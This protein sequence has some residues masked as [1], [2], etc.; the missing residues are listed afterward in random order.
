MARASL[1]GGV[2][3][4]SNTVATLAPQVLALLF[5]APPQYAVFSL[6]FITLGLAQSAQNSLVVDPWL[7]LDRHSSRLPTGAVVWAA[8]P[9]AL[10]AAA[11]PAALG[12]LSASEFW[13]AALGVCAAQSRNSL[14]LLG[15]VM[16]WRTVVASDI[17]F[18]SA[19]GAVVALLAQDGI[20]WSTIWWGIVAG[21]LAGLAPWASHVSDA[22]CPPLRWFASRR[23]EILPLWLES[24]VL[25]LGVAGPPVAFSALMPASDF[26]IFRATSSALL[27]VRLVLTPLR[28]RIAL[29]NPEALR[30]G[31]RFAAVCTAGGVLGLT[32]SV[33]LYVV[34]SWSVASDGVLPLLKSYAFQVGAMGALQLVSTTFY[35]ASRAHS[36]TA[37]LVRTRLV[38]TSQQI[39]CLGAGF[40]IGGLTG[41][42]WGYVML[43]LASAVLWHWSLRGPTP[44][45][46]HSY[47]DGS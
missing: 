25:D 33:A 4:A 19:F 15:V 9:L 38:D 14:R 39:I 40:V 16:S 34:A 29:Q 31:M 20:A 41:A 43:S 7:R 23:R 3:L 26:A 47:E 37:R 1:W 24:T 42:V 11:L 18:I 30:S 21:G 5:L 45:A 35:M 17:L 8:F 32:I 6:L 10:L 44:S 27:P 12:Y 2:G 46:A 36:S 28:G 13:L 22:A